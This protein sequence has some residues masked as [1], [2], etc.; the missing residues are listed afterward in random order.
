MNAQRNEVEVFSWKNRDIADNELDSICQELQ[1]WI[2]RCTDIK[3][4]LCHVAKLNE[5]SISEAN[6]RENKVVF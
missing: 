3:E 1:K 2:Q 5:K 4:N 6:E